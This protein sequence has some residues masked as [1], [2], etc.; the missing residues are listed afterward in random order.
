[1]HIQPVKVHK[2]Y[3]EFHR[4][5]QINFMGEYDDHHHLIAVYNSSHEYLTHVMDTQQWLL[6]SQNQLYFIEP[7]YSAENNQD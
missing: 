6:A 7:D 3:S 5:P 2:M 4:S 1:M